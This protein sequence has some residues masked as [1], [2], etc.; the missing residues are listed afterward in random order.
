MKVNLPGNNNYRY[1]KKKKSKISKIFEDHHSKCTAHI[2]NCSF[3]GKLNQIAEK[4]IKGAAYTLV[5]FNGKLL[6]SINSTVS[7]KY[8]RYVE[9]LK[10]VNLSVMELSVGVVLFFRCGCLNGQQIRS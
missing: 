4:E 2:C 5:E 8:R 9:S 10:Q 6:A 1:S 7:R 3:I